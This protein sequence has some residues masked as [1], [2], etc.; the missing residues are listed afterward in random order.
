MTQFLQYALLG[1]AGGGLY[2]LSSLGIVAIY[3][4]SGIVNFA[5]GSLAA[6]GAYVYW[7]CQSNAGLPWPAAMLAGL[8]SA[9]VLGV[10]IHWLIMKPMANSSSLART[11]ATLGVLV[12]VQAALQLLVPATLVNVKSIL[13]TS[14]IRIGSVAIGDDRLW[15]LGLAVVITAALTVT[16]R[17]SRLGLATA[18]VAE[19]PRA[20]AALSLSPD[21]VA[22]VTWALGSALAALAGILLAPILGLQ[23]T[24]LTALLVPSLAAAVTGGMTSFTITCAAGVVIGVV[25]SELTL[26]VTTPGWGPTVPFLVL[27]VVMVVRGRAIP[28]R[29]EHTERLPRVSSGRIRPIPIAIGIAAA[30]FFIWGPLGVNFTD[31]TAVTAA[32][33][34]ILLS[35]VVVTGYAGQISLCQYAFAGLGAF[36]AG[37]LIGAFGWPIEAAVAV[38]VVA[39]A[40]SGLIVGLPA[41]RTRGISLAIITLGFAVMVQELILSNPSINGG[42]NPDDIGTVRVFGYDIDAIA[43]PTRYAA[44]AVIVFIIAAICVVNV[45]RG[46]VGRRLLAIRESERAAAS[47]G[48][49]RLGP[50]LYAFALSAAI[51]SLGGILVTFMD[52]IM[53]YSTSF[54]DFQSVY[55]I[56]YAVLGGVGFV[57]GAIVGA[58]FDPA[59]LTA[60]I[61]HSFQQGSFALWFELIGGAILLQTLL[62]NPDGVAP[63]LAA[64]LRALGRR[65]LGLTG[66]RR[67]QP[68]GRQC[69]E[70]APTSASGTDGTRTALSTA[71]TSLSVDAAT[72]RFG[73]VT[74]LDGV[75]FE[76]ASGEVFGIIGPN[77][78]G[79]TTIIDAIT[80]FVPLA[81]GRVSLGDRRVDGKPPAWRARAGLTRSF[82]GLELFDGLTVLENLQM[83]CDTGSRW[84]YISDLIWPRRGRLSRAAL[85]AID[86]FDLWDDLTKQPAELPFGRRRMVA[87]ARAVAT[88]PSVLLLDEP[89]AGLGDVE[90][91]ELGTLV[92]ELASA[93]DM[94]VVLIEHNVEMVLKV[95][96]RVMLLDFGHKLGEGTPSEMRGNEDLVRAYLGGE[97]LDPSGPVP[98]QPSSNSLD[99]ATGAWS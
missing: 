80:G 40:V 13:P 77:G 45:R 29:G 74:A 89:A 53:T 61:F 37:R 69:G 62:T 43:H 20:A 59:S 6:V 32:V 4:G 64:Q 24:I 7:V 54:D 34:L 12:V 50:K 95:S 41:L 94:A 27:L 52:P 70:I 18:A 31:A 58:Q 85:V 30:I 21:K 3:R 25:E 97:P 8:C 81:G 99:Q 33:A 57:G 96:D 46:S 76:V 16:A 65:M 60:T 84:A 88:A 11:V 66:S 98:E 93:Y 48:I 83:A 79:K 15:I 39:A 72:V 28:V 51:A 63:Q 49:N 78:A 87:I 1:L 91:A 71:A 86:H 14:T 67:S 35:Y 26:Y 36:V 22:C 38:G 56:G 82:Q 17:K 44:F 90:A 92:R 68:S 23:V 55:A 42:I 10:G 73:G 5:H 47:L 2:A 19:N 75:S 9:A